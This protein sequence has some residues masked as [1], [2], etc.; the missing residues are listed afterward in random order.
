MF[1]VVFVEGGE[2]GENQA[3]PRGAAAVEAWQ[4]QPESRIERLRIGALAFARAQSYVNEGP[5]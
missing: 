1:L 3:V 4:R 2:K 5:N